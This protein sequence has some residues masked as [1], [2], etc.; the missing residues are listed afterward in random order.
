MNMKK[1]VC[2]LLLAQSSF[3]MAQTETFITT[4]GKK[5]EINPNSLNTADN[6]LSASNGK[7]QLGGTLNKPTQIVTT[8]S[9]TLTIQGL[10]T[11]AG[12]DNVLV[13][14]ANGVLKWVTRSSFL[15]DNLGNH[16]AAQN[17]NMSN[18]NITNISNAYIKNE[19]QI[20]DRTPENTNYFSLYKSNGIFGIYSSNK[21]GNPLEI[22]EA[23]GKNTVSS[24]RITKGTDNIAPVAG[25]I[26]TSADNI[27][28]VKWVAPSEVTPVGTAFFK[29]TLQSDVSFPSD[30]GKVKFDN[31]IVD[32]SNLKASIVDNSGTYSIFVV[33]KTGFYSITAAVYQFFASTGTISTPVTMRGSVYINNETTGTKIGTV[34]LYALSVSPYYWT[35]GLLTSIEKLNAGDKISVSFSNNFASQSGINAGTNIAG[36]GG[37]P[38]VTYFSGYFI[39]E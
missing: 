7:V 18:K 28:N 3:M 22:D 23:T 14:D 25:A 19:A 6:G 37:H 38:S 36:D 16:T 13:A 1:I 17:L 8:S 26:A 5:V 9:N 4:N 31:K 32:K 33:P 20:L 27:G 24:L 39:S 12:T 10:Q 15:G 30:N 21:G 11:G 29:Y 34:D 35:P 2:M